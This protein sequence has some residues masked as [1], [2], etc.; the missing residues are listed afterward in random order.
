MILPYKNSWLHRQRKPLQPTRLQRCGGG[1]TPRWRRVPPCHLTGTGCCSTSLAGSCK[2]ERVS[3]IRWSQFPSTVRP[4]RQNP[5]ESASL[6]VHSTLEPVPACLAHRA[7][8]IAHNRGAKRSSR[9]TRVS[10]HAT[11][12]T[13]LSWRCALTPGRAA[14]WQGSWATAPQRMPGTAAAAP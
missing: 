12:L 1:S 2:Q 10:S 5:D 11:Q 3:T 9:P 8:K 7:I 4:L 13:R 14:G 6:Q